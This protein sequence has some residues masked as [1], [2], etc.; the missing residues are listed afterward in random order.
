MRSLPP[1]SPDAPSSPLLW[2]GVLGA[3]LAWTLQFSVGYWLAESRC[4]E[5]GGQLFG[6]ALDVWMVPLT[7]LAVGAS[8]AAWLVAL[9]LYR[10]SA[11]ASEYGPPPGGRNHFLAVI[12]LAIAP[13][14][15]VLIALTALGVFFH[16]P[17]CTQS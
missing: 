11:E 10:R 6:V 1:L 9:G 7:A 17:P 8:V 14:F 3:P 13:L 16:F 4:S 2:F 12:G 15:T 5:S